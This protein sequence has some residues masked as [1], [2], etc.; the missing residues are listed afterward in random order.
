[1]LFSY[2]LFA[3]SPQREVEAFDDVKLLKTTKLIYPNPSYGDLKLNLDELGLVNYVLSV[4]NIIGKPLWSEEIKAD[5][6][7]L[8]LGFLSKGTYM[9]CIAKPSG[10]YLRVIRLVIIDP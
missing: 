5:Q 4:N 1:M 7:I 6:K 9:F 10:E 8:D 3:Q 2:S